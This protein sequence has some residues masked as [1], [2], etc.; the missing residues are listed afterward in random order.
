[1]DIQFRNVTQA[2]DML[3]TLLTIDSAETGSD[4][5]AAAAVINGDEDDLTENDLIAVDIDAVQTTKAKGLIVTL[6]FA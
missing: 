2:A 5:A 4:S 6:G 1:M 3:S